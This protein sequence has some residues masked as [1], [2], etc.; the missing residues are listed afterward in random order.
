MLV[1]DI[2]IKTTMDRFY[3]LGIRKKERK[4][5]EK[6]GF[7][8]SGNSA[9]APIASTFATVLTFTCHILLRRKLTAPVVSASLEL[10]SSEP[11]SAKCQ[12]GSS[13]P[14]LPSPG[15]R[16]PYHGEPGDTIIPSQLLKPV[17]G[18]TGRRGAL[19]SNSCLVYRIGIVVNVG[20]QFYIWKTKLK[21]KEPFVHMYTYIR[22]EQSLWKFAGWEEVLVLEEAVWCLDQSPPCL[23]PRSTLCCDLQQFMELSCFS[24]IICKWGDDTLYGCEDRS[25]FTQSTWASAWDAAN[26]AEVFALL[27]SLMLTQARHN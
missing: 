22:Q 19:S 5:L 10:A 27:I 18:L 24:F 26:S 23:N 7:V 6:A 2:Q 11:N 20:T 8:Q 9:L 16:T 1:L 25:S 13:S 15:T 12:M 4:L 21:P 14:P 3:L 17:L